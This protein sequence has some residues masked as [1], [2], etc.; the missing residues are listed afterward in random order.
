M[1]NATIT[2]SK[3]QNR[4]TYYIQML[5]SWSNFSAGDRLGLAHDSLTD[6]K[7]GRDPLALASSMG[8]E[9]SVRIPR[10]MCRLVRVNT[11]RVVTTTETV[12]ESD[13]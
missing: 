8:G 11:K 6:W 9:Y 2:T 4:T 13:V 1:S 5:Y 7:A 12:E 10:T 3:E